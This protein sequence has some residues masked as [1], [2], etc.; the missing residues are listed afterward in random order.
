V[1]GIVK[2]HGG[3][4]DVESFPEQGSQFNIF[5]PATDVA[6]KPDSKRGKNDDKASGNGESILVVEDEEIVRELASRVLRENGYVVFEAANASEARTIFDREKGNF[7]LIFSDVIMPDVNGTQL[8]DQLLLL[9]SNL[10]ALFS[11]GYSDEK[12]QRHIIVERGFPFLQKPYTPSD[13]LLA[14]RD[15]IAKT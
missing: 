9:K 10:K 15:T 12:S 3:W 2:Q 8:V 14:I 11:S 4:I 5:L 13:L 1:Y 6:I 7:D